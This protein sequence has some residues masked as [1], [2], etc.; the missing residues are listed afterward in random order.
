MG[1]GKH[2]K[3]KIYVI[4]YNNNISEEKMIRIHEE[5]YYRAMKRIET[6]KQ[7]LSVKDAE[8]EPEKSEKKKYKLYEEILFALNVFICPWKIN[9][10]IHLRDQV[11]N[12]ILVMFVALGLKGIGGMM[13]L[14]G[15]IILLNGIVKLVKRTYE[16]SQAISVFIISA[17]LLFLGGIIILSGGEFE[18]EEDSNRIYA[19]SASIIA[20]VSCVVSIISLLRM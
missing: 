12:S 17:I 4:E 10:K 8:A 7:R 5:A 13:R 3:K 1:R 9:K 11:Y 16:L 19:F 20:L 18:K 6:E 14:T 2:R 15:I